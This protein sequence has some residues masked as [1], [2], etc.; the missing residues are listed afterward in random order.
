MGINIY[1]YMVC[2]VCGNNDIEF[3]IC[4]GCTA[5]ISI[6]TYGSVDR[7][8]ALDRLLERVKDNCNC[9]IHE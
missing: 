9:D 3:G 6:L 7:K 4:D 1:I 5:D 2:E 8:K